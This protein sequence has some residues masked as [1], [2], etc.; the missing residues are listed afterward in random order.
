MYIYS[1]YDFSFY[2]RKKESIIQNVKRIK[3]GLFK[4]HCNLIEAKKAIS[5]FQ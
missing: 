1:R 5:Y 4:K 3:D 2:W